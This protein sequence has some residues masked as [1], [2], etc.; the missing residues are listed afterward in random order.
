MKI[1]RSI[2]FA[3]MKSEFNNKFLKSYFHFTNYIFPVYGEKGAALYDLLTGE[4][5]MVKKDF[6]ELL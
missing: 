6:L 1:L 4:V 3:Y 5:F 2:G